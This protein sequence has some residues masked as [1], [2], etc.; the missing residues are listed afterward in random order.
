ALSTPFLYEVEVLADRN[1]DVPFDKLLGQEIGLT[2]RIRD[3]TGAGVRTRFLTGICNRISQGESDNAFT[4]YRLDLVPALWFLTKSVRSRVFQQKSVPDIL[5]Q[6]LFQSLNKL[7]VE[8]PLEPRDHCMQ[9]DESDFDFASRLME[10]EGFYYYFD[11]SGFPGPLVVSNMP[12]GH[13]T[14]PNLGPH[15]LK[16]LARDGTPDFGVIS[17]WE[18]VQEVRAKRCALWDHHFQMT[19]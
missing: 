7:H 19:P 3:K 1:V 18:K 14:N 2:M 13:N 15:V 5:K 12:N 4:R 9:Y 11:P 6:V 8:K 10:E 17:S 16:T